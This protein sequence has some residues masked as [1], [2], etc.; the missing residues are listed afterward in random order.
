M[1]PCNFWPLWVLGKHPKCYGIS[2]VKLGSPAPPVQCPDSVPCEE[3]SVVSRFF[4]KKFFGVNID[5]IHD[6]PPDSAYPKFS[7]SPKSPLAAPDFVRDNQK[8]ESYEN[9]ASTQSAEGPPPELPRCEGRDHPRYE[10]P[11]PHHAHGMRDLRRFS[12]LNRGH[13]VV[14]MRLAHRYS[15]IHRHQICY[16]ASASRP[17]KGLST[18]L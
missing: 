8:F 5:K 15:M 3:V 14:L 13:Y 12:P 6:F 11:A 16:M 1:V 17:P 9:P 2:N 10:R 4:S 7:K 18:R